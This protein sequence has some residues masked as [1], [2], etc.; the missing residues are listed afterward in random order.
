M[1]LAELAAEISPDV[2]RLAEK[3]NYEF[4]HTWQ[5]TRLA[6]RLFDELKPLHTLKKKHRTYLLYGALLHDIGWCRGGQG[7]HKSA[8]EIITSDPPSSLKEDEVPIVALIARYHRKAHPQTKH[9]AYARL[10][11]FDRDVVAKLASLLRIADGLDRSHQSL[12]SD[13]FCSFDKESVTIE[14]C[15]TGSPPA[16]EIWGA[17]R[18]AALFE[19]V[20]HRK[21]TIQR[22]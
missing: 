7:H 18:K 15:F 11:V 2:I 10:S 16:V 12:V 13:L 14:L 9:N 8:F 4:E 19:E 6:A 22:Q 1:A 21:L 5:V 17:E 20:F 3:C